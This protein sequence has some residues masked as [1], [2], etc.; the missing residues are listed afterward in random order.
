MDKLQTRTHELASDDIKYTF[1]EEEEEGEAVEH[2]NRDL[3]AVVCA[4]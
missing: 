2:V 3:T 1:D 4:L